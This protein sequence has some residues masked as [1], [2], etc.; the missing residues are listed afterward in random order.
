MLV[1][2]VVACARFS[3]MTVDNM[4]L[5]TREQEGRSMGYA[6]IRPPGLGTYP[7]I[8]TSRPLRWSAF[9][10]CGVRQVRGCFQVRRSC[11]RREGG[12]WRP[13]KHFPQSRVNPLNDRPLRM[14][15]SSCEQ[16][17]QTG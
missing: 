15:G 2:E 1:L 17:S 9:E 5:R 6:S 8:E 10:E 3:K 11:F 7:S 4:C 14:Q 13:P 12:R 16:T